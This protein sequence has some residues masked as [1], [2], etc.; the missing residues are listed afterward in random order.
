MPVPA[1]FMPFEPVLCP[2]D[3]EGPR[4]GRVLPVEHTDGCAIH[5]PVF[6]PRSGRMFV[7]APKT[8]SQNTE[9]HRYDRILGIRLPS[10]EVT[11]VFGDEWSLE[12]PLALLIDERSQLMASESRIDLPIGVGSGHNAQIPDG[13]RC[14]PRRGA[15]RRREITR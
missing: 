5:S 8:P 3:P 1:L 10:F 6:E 4:P 14:R 7:A 9:G 15:K 2:E 11:D 12:D 13:R